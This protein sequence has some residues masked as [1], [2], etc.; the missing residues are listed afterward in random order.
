MPLIWALQIS[1]SLATCK[2]CVWPL[3]QQTNFFLEL[4]Q[5]R[6]LPLTTAGCQ[7]EFQ[8][9]RAPVWLLHIFHCSIECQ[10]IKDI[11][12]PCGQ[13]LEVRCW[14]PWGHRKQLLQNQRSTTGWGFW[15]ALW[16]QLRQKGCELH[17]EQTSFK[18]GNPLLRHPKRSCY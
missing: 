11:L 3:T 7:E 16:Q 13:G 15:G 18:T 12:E 2:Y 8:A 6:E 4:F 10:N 5:R 17:G 9:L 14:K 1:L